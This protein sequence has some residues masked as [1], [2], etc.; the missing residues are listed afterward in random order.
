MI[1]LQIYSAPRV[2][3]VKHLPTLISYQDKMFHSN[4]WSEIMIAK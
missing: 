1:H 2:V 3:R 4:Y